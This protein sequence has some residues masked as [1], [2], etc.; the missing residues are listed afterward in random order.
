M[1]IFVT[2]H[3]LR[4][5]LVSQY[6]PCARKMFWHTM[7]DRKYKRNLNVCYC[8]LFNLCNVTKWPW[9][10]CVRYITFRLIQVKRTKT[11]FFSAQDMLCILIR[12]WRDWSVVSSESI[13]LAFLPPT[14]GIATYTIYFIFSW[15]LYISVQHGPLLCVIGCTGSWLEYEAV[16]RHWV[17]CKIL[18]T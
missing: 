16:E 13:T 3:G 12:A 14:A 6:V 9:Y 10:T 17:S 4:T 2:L 8:G 7:R 15:S 1:A 5:L 11:F 18:V